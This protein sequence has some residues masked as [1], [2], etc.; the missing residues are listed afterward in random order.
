[1][2]KFLLPF[3]IF[4]MGCSHGLQAPKAGPTTLEVINASPELAELYIDRDFVT[5]IEPESR[6]A[7]RGFPAG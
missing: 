3:T 1:M 7:L 6:R 5:T 4:A 2:L